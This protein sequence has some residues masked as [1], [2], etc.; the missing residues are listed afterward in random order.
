MASWFNPTD[1]A[2]GVLESLDKRID[3]NAEEAKVYKEEQRDLAKQSKQAI[4]NRTTLVQQLLSVANKLKAQGVSQAQVKAAHSAGPDALLNLS[5]QVQ[6]Y[7]AKKGTAKLSPDEVEAMIT[8]SDLTQMSPEVQSMNLKEFLNA[9]ANMPNVNTVTETADERNLLERALGVGQKDAIR[10][11][12]DQDMQPGGYSLADL[13][14]SATLASYKSIMPGASAT[15]TAPVD[16]KSSNAVTRFDTFYRGNLSNNALLN[17]STYLSLQGQGATDEELLD[18]RNSKIEGFVRGQF[19]DFGFQALTDPAMNYK[20]KLGEERYIGL[21]NDLE[22]SD[23]EMQILNPMFN[24]DGETSKISYEGEDGSKTIVTQAADG[25]V[26]SIEVIKANGTSEIEKGNTAN[27]LLSLI[28]NDGFLTRDTDTGALTVSGTSTVDSESLKLQAIALEERRVERLS[29]NEYLDE[30]EA[31]ANRASGNFETGD[32]ITIGQKKFTVDATAD[33]RM[34]FALN[35]DQTPEVQNNKNDLT[36][37]DVPAIAKSIADW[38]NA[39][40]QETFLIKSEGLDRGWLEVNKEELEYLR[41]T[42]SA[43]VDAD[44]ASI[45][46]KDS[47]EGK[48]VNA[49]NIRSMSMNSL[50]RMLKSKGLNTGE[51]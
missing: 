9:T 11:K 41:S 10:V 51:E 20:D 33:G 32:I 30:N 36:L 28:L 13:N 35:E 22:L 12:L 21:I 34:F 1:F 38:W 23:A 49:Y 40:P 43:L 6:T 8:T 14:E 18:Y 16:Y 48:A 27:Q 25:T 15:F 7:L 44:N 3:R 50:K 26:I 17:D 31:L 4:A 47:E 42:N 19:A 24:D 46:K 37:I 39:E 5:T 2:T 45:I 29:K